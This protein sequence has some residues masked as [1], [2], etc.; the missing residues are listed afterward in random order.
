[1]RVN[2]TPAIPLL[3]PAMVALTQFVA[4]AVV[5]PK[6]ERLILPVHTLLLPYSAI[7]VCHIFPAQWRRLARG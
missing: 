2:N 3:L 5:Y 4:L 7:A 6:G 1:M